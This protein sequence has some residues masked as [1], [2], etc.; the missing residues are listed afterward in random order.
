MVT[1]ELIT[2]IRQELADGVSREDIVKLLTPNGWSPQDIAEAFT[3]V[4]A[5]RAIAPG[6]SVQKDFFVHRFCRD[7]GCLCFFPIYSASATSSRYRGVRTD[8]QTKPASQ[9]SRFRRAVIAGYRAGPISTN[10]R[11]YR[12]NPDSTGERATDTNSDSS[13]YSSGFGTNSCSQTCR[14]VRRRHLYRFRHRR[15][16]WH[17]SG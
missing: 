6:Y 13:G 16:L 15:V 8:T 4:S 9:S 3:A 11:A 5:Q 17:G 7:F 10:N 2:Y 14:S 12:H 1:P